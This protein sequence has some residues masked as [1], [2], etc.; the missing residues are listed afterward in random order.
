MPCPAPISKIT[1]FLVFGFLFFSTLPV[2]NNCLDY[3][4]RINIPQDVQGR[5]WGIIG[6]ISQMGYVVA[7]ATAG[8]AAD[9]LGTLTGKGVGSGAAMGIIISGILLMFFSIWLFSQKD[10]KKLEHEE[11]APDVE[12]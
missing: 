6:F 3:L 12:K 1:L 4:I 7:Y 5:A 10:I 8:L 9:T 11:V 2:T